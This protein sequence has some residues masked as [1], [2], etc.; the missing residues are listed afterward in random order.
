MRSC[1]SIYA[2][3][4]LLVMCS[5]AIAETLKDPAAARQITDRIMA[6]VSAGDMEAGLKLAKPFLIIPPAEFD[7]MLD[8]LKMQQPAMTQRFGQSIGSEFIRQDAVG[9]S[10]LRIVQ[11]HRFEKHA[12]RWVF[13]FYRGKDG[14]VLNTFKTDD[15]IRLL[16]TEG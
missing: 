7:V 1:R 15:D 8:R 11:I 6:K 16:F 13:Y 3:A 2:L 5:S 14:W 12:M 10:V 4:L 9:E